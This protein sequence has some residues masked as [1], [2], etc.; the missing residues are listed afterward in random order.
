MKVIPTLFCRTFKM[1][2][3]IAHVNGKKELHSRVISSYLSRFH[4]IPDITI[5]KAAE[6]EDSVC[7]LE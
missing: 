1:A 7:V 3:V 2:N 6:V 5:S 4:D